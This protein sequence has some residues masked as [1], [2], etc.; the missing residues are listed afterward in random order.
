[1]P[2]GALWIFLSGPSFPRQ[3]ALETSMIQR[4]TP[5]HAPGTVRSKSST[6]ESGVGVAVSHRT[7]G[8][9]VQK[10]R[11]AV[12]SEE[13]GKPNRQFHD[14]VVSLHFSVR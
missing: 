12:E 13:L 3:D 7:K 5:L 10:S 6:R 4:S 11:E 8:T 14:G 1:M 9:Q 2:E